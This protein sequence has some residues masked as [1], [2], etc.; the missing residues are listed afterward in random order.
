MACPVVD[1]NKE[2]N[3]IFIYGGGV[4][5]AK[6]RLEDVEGTIYVRVLKKLENFL[7]DII[8]GMYVSSLFQEHGTEAVPKELIGQY[9]IGDIIYV[10]PVHSCMTGNL[11]R[12]YL[13]LD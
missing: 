9:K 7:G 11:M 13:T 8:P 3:K 12:G 2:R 1:I 10:L 4:H 6:D 5:F